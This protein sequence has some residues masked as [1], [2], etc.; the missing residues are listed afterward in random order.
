LDGQVS[1]RDLLDTE[2]DPVAVLR[3]E[4]HGF[5]NQQ[6]EGAGQ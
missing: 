3:A 1:A 2:Q 4:G 6:I 5:E